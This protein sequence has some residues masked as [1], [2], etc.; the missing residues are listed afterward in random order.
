M[1]YLGWKARIL[2]KPRI[3]SQCGAKIFKSPFIIDKWIKYTNIKRS[4][5]NI[6]ILTMYILLKF[7][8]GILCVCVCVRE[9][10]HRIEGERERESDRCR[11]LILKVEMV[12]V[13]I[14]IPHSLMSRMLHKVNFYTEFNWFKFRVFI[15]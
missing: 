11:L 1:I 4:I 15:R 6:K 12:T 2:S 8:L 14:Y 10:E 13:C 9:R 7:S 3:Y 5:T